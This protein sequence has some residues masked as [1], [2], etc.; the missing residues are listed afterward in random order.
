MSLKERIKL[1]EM[2]AE[3]LL[4][5]GSRFYTS[6]LNETAPQK[7]ESQAVVTEPEVVQE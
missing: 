2:D 4:S 5:S 1:E 7:K 6:D 3:K